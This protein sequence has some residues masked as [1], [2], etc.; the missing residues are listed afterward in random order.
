MWKKSSNDPKGNNFFYNSSSE[1]FLS[2]A[3]EYKKGAG[4]SAG[5]VVLRTPE[6]LSK[7]LSNSAKT[8]ILQEQEG[9]YD[10]L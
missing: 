7:D 8:T 3:N 2:V 10:K 5:H 6:H 1:A 9:V 4:V